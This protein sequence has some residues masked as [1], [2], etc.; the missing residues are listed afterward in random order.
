MCMETHSKHAEPPYKGRLSI[1]IEVLF[2][3]RE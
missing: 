3:S 1:T 2:L